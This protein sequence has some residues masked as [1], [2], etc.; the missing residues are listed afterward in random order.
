MYYC[1]FFLQQCWCCRYFFLLQHRWCYG[2]KFYNMDVV[3]DIF[4]AIGN[5][6][7]KQKKN[8]AIR[9]H[10]R[11][12]CPEA[13][14]RHGSLGRASAI[15]DSSSVLAAA[16]P[17]KLSSRL[18]SNNQP[19]CLARRST[20]A[21]TPGWPRP[22]ASLSCSLQTCRAGSPSNSTWPWQGRERKRDRKQWRIRER[23]I[24]VS[25][26]KDNARWFLDVAWLHTTRDTR[27]R[28]RTRRCF[29][30]ADSSQC[31]PSS[32]T[33]TWMSIFLHF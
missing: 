7:Q 19:T 23:R 12:F 18:A 1:S 25:V 26:H 2:R 22:T 4:L 9:R 13:V 24:K 20:A 33:C 32:S 10:L 14:S 15:A 27:A 11:T 16:V 21:A 8:W 5:I 6:K 17:E 30:P 29:Q 3:V 31:F 28:R